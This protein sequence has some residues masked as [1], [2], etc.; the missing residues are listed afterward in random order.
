MT[1]F[2]DTSSLLKLYYTEEGSDRLIEALSE[3]ADAI[4]LSEIA[5]AEFISAI[6][7]KVR[8]KQIKEKTARAVIACFEADFKKY[9]WVRIRP[10]IIRQA[11]DLIK[12]YGHDGLRTLDSIQ[13]S[14]AVQLK[15]E[16]CTFFTSDKLLH[17][18]FEK[19]ELYTIPDGKQERDGSGH[20]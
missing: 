14:C 15:D 6:W 16:N 3:G 1:A 19:E 8:R 5:K 17:K 2:L 11:I 20:K 10:K 7:K 13:L 18:L 12:K 4:Y 9:S